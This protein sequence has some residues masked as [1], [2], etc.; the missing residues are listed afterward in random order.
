MELYTLLNKLMFAKLSGFIDEV[1]EEYIILNVNDVGYMVYCSNKT[2]NQITNNNKKISLYIETIVKEDSIT[3][4]GFLTK[5]DKEVFNIL[6]KVN[7]V[8]SKMAIKIMS[9]LSI[10]E[11]SIALANSDLKLF[12]RVPGIGSKLATRVVS[13]LKDC[14][15]TRNI[16]VNLNNTT[17]NEQT[18]KMDN[19]IINDAIIALEGLGYQKSYA[20]SIVINTIKERPDLT[21]ESVITNS[22]K[23]INNI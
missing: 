1:F 13:E 9:I 3:L 8:G 19:N 14:F 17:E 2:I 23:K 20:K 7:G 15:L 21:L 12:C 18:I 10:N 11:I 4:F 22:L 5:L 6:C 16:N